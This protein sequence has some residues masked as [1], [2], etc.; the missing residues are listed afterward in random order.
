[1]NVR[2]IA[3]VQ[4]GEFLTVVLLSED[5]RRAQHQVAVLEPK[6][7]YG[8][9]EDDDDNDDNDEDNDYDNDD[10]DGNVDDDDDDR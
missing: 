9:D 3:E 7:Y 10:D 1:M 8:D 5:R 4:L 2:A 6:G